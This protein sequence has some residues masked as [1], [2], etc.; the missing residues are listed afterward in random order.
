MSLLFRRRSA[1]FPRSSS[2]LPHGSDT[3]AYCRERWK[4]LRPVHARPR[5]RNWQ[6]HCLL[7]N[8]WRQKSRTHGQIQL[9]NRGGAHLPIPSHFISNFESTS[10]RPGSKLKIIE[11]D[12][13]WNFQI[14]NFNGFSH[15]SISDKIVF[16]PWNQ[17]N[18]SQNQNKAA[19][20]SEK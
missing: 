15:L 4:R 3:R 11:L 14:S 10:I 5:P 1:S 6:A 13:F 8:D 2:I 7:P 12:W 16:E 17:L 20:Y 9:S 18:S 19:F